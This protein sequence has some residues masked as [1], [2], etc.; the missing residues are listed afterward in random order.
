M[1]A[2]SRRLLGRVSANGCTCRDCD[3][4]PDIDGGDLPDQMREF[5]RVEI[6]GSFLVDLGWNVSL[7]KK[8]DRIG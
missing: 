4:V 8:G 5:L 7:G 6:A 2:H 1:N 3:A